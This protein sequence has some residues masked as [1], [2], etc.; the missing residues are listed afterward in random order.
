MEKLHGN[1]PLHVVLHPER[2]MCTLT[3]SETKYSSLN[4]TVK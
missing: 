2:K 1:T 3:P 4:R